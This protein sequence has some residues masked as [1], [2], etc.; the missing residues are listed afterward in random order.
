MDLNKSDFKT[1]FG[2]V[3]TEM[4]M[5]TLFDEYGQFALRGNVEEFAKRIQNLIIRHQWVN[6]FS[7]TL[8]KNITLENLCTQTA[9]TIIETWADMCRSKNLTDSQMVIG[10]RKHIH[11]MNHGAGAN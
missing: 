7:I 4:Q 3:F 10:C 1:G 8:E 9:F 5:Q 6:V 11:D 2:S